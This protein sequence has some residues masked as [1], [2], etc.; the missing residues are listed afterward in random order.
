MPI[1][2]LV[3][4]SGD[5]C[6][7]GFKLLSRVTLGE[8]LSLKLIGEREFRKSGI[9]EIHISDGVGELGD[10]CFYTCYI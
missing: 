4:E 9:I 2:D 7:Y 5:E 3:E 10:E 1:A 8:S 6:F